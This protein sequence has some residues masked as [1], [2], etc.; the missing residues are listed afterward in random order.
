MTK[1]S[2]LAFINEEIE[3]LKQVRQLLGSSE[4]DGTPRVPGRRGKWRMSAEARA[5]I[6]AAQKA[7]WAKR[8]A[9]QKGISGGARRKMSAEGRARIAAAQKARWARQRETRKKK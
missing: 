3:R 9:G 7:R 1:A 2:V 6:S 5:R 4:S 8:K